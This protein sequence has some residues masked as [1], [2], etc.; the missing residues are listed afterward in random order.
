MKLTSYWL[1][2]APSFTAGSKEPVVGKADVL[3]VGGG[4]TGSPAMLARPG[5]CPLWAPITA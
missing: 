5:S 4:L 1:D 2:T 3:I